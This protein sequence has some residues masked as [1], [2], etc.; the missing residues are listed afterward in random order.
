MMRMMVM[1][2]FVEQRTGVVLVVFQCIFLYVCTIQINDLS[3]LRCN[4]LNT[5]SS[6]GI[7][8]LLSFKDLL[9]YRFLLLLETS[10]QKMQRFFRT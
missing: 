4:A 10:W 8:R 7:I 3:N 2:I 6:K 9:F 5:P 1:G